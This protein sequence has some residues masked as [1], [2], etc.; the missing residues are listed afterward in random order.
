M[1]VS[2]TEA[3]KD[4]YPFQLWLPDECAVFH[5]PSQTLGQLSNMAIGLPLKVLGAEVGSS[6][7]LYQALRFGR[8]PDIQERVLHADHPHMS[9]RVS[10][11]H[12]HRSAEDWTKIRVDVMRWCIFVKLS[13]HRDRLVPVLADTGLRPIVERS[14]V[15]DYWGAITTE[16]GLTGRNVLGCLWTDLRRRLGQRSAGPIHPPLLPRGLVLLGKPL[17]L[18]DPL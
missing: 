16:D 9:K 3:R 2:V 4:D 17:P 6:E 7:A 12:L 18:L 10:R 5:R 13:Q 8:D 11:E 1:G 14:S 15:D